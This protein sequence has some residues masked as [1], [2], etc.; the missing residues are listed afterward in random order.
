MVTDENF[1]E[2]LIE[3]LEEAAAHR[4]GELTAASVVRRSAPPRLDAFVAMDPDDDWDDDPDSPPR[5]HEPR[6]RLR[7]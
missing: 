4:R 1:G 2:L 7:R 6:N 5:E 3:G